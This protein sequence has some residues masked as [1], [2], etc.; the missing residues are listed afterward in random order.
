MQD[1]SSPSAAAP[2]EKVLQAVN[3]SVS[4]RAKGGDAVAVDGASFGVARGEMFA[5]VGESGCGK[6]TVALALLGLLRSPPARVEGRVALE[7]RD[8]MDLP[9]AELQ[10]I[11]GKRIAMIFQQ[12]MTSLNPVLTIERQLTESMMVHDGIARSEAIRRARDLLELVGITSPEMR[13]RQYPHQLS[14][15]MRQRVMIAMAMSCRPAVLVADEPTTALDVTMQAQIL[16]LIKGLKREFG[17]ATLL[18]THDLGVVAENADRVAV[19]YAGRI[20]EQAA[21]AELFREPAHPY[22]RG[23]IAAV[24]RLDRLADGPGRNRMQEIPG[25]VPQAGSIVPGCSFAPRCPLATDRCRTERPRE[26]VIAPGH[27]VSCWE[28]AA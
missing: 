3:L 13:L 14:G 21:T 7:G 12:P 25:A 9:P 20:V 22:S 23:L 11:R 19:M 1:V 5:L 16:S 24:P 15:G 28:Y 4:F 2:G 8:I 10:R 18:I 6:S 27:V 26:I 17:V